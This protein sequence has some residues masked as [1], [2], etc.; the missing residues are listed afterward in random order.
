MTQ[1]TVNIERAL[2]TIAKYTQQQD[3]TNAAE[4][5]GVHLEGPFISEHKVGAQHP[6]FVQRPTVDKIKSFQKVANGLIKI[7]TYAPEVDGATET[8]KTMKNDIIFSIGHTVA[9]FDQANAAVSHGAKHITHLYNA[10]LLYTSPS[11]RD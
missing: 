10:C 11:P 7:I 9:T 6:Q 1:S 8:L 4:I 3:V 2:Q 5:V